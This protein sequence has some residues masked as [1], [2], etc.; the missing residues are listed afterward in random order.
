MCG[1][2]SSNVAA[3]S[4]QADATGTDE[5]WYRV[6]YFPTFGSDTITEDVQGLDAARTRLMNPASRESEEAQTWGPGGT[7]ARIDA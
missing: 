7:Y 6:A 4:V 1:C 3:E 2:G 5:T